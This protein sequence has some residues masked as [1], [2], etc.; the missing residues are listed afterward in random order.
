[1]RAHFCCKRDRMSETKQGAVSA[2]LPILQTQHKH[3]GLQSSCAQSH[4]VTHIPCFLY[5]QDW[6]LRAGHMTGLRNIKRMRSLSA[7]ICMAAPGCIVACLMLLSPLA[8]LAATGAAPAGRVYINP[9]MPAVR[10]SLTPPISLIREL[11]MQPQCI[12]CVMISVAAC[13]CNTSG[14]HPADA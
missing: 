10:G 8:A 5:L 13:E 9:N 3:I 7:P 11:N 1:M 4:T 6:A 12:C 14:K 2:R